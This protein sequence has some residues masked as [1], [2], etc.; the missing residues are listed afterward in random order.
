[1]NLYVVILGGPYD[2]ETYIIRAENEK[3]AVELARD[4]GNQD[5]LLS[6][7]ELDWEGPGRVLIRIHTGE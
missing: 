1:M 5:T 4:D 3:H 2:E 7:E 6:V